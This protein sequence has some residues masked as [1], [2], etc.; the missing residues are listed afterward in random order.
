MP[1]YFIVTYTTGMPQLEIV[2]GRRERYQGN[3]PS[4]LWRRLGPEGKKTDASRTESRNIS[5][6]R[7]DGGGGGA[8]LHSLRE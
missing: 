1:F 6:I 7:V 3:E 2:E 5:A 4:E 8:H